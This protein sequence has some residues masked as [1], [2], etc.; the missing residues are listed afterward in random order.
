MAT[1]S[2]SDALLFSKTYI[3][4]TVQVANSRARF[5]LNVPVNPYSLSADVS[6]TQDAGVWSASV[7]VTRQLDIA[8]TGIVNILDFSII[9]LDYGSS[10]GDLRY[11]PAADL[12]AS[13][14]VNVIDASIMSYYY[15][16]PVFY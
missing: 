4:A 15:N 12:T 1:N 5:V 14:T 8:K 13:G 10:P 9:A 3:V 11:N 2:S 7:M 6:V 16:A